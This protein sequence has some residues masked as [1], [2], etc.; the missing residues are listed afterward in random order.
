[1]PFPEMLLG[2]DNIDLGCT[3]P[4]VLVRKAFL[5]NPIKE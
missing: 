3:V 5:E 2:E 4:G 1:M